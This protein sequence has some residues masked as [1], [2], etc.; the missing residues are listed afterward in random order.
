[1][2]LKSTQK[3][4]IHLARYLR[5]FFVGILAEPAF[6]ITRLPA[7]DGKRLR[8]TRGLKP[9]SKA[10]KIGGVGQIAPS[11]SACNNRPPSAPTSRRKAPHN[12]MDLPLVTLTTDFGTRDSYVA[13]MKGAML[14]RA[15]SLNIVDLSHD[16][17]PQDVALAARFISEACP[18]FP[19]GTI[20]VVVVDPGVGTDRSILLAELQ[21]QRFVCPDNGLLTYLCTSDASGT[22]RKLNAGKKYG[23][24]SQTFHGR[25]LMGPA[26]VDWALGAPIHECSVLIQDI[27]Q[28]PLSSPECGSHQCRGE[29]IGT[30]SFG[31]LITNVTVSCLPSPLPNKISVQLVGRSDQLTWVSTYGE[32]PQGCLVA[33]VGSSGRV[34]IAQVNGSAARQLG[35]QPNTEVHVAW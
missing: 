2:A 12:P 17:P 19:E 4:K 15:P 30:D 26:A 34:E 35:L 16:I 3:F 31:N 33:L 21:E 9:C 7:S 23:P 1:L 24:P 28:I 20:H 6:P 22:F 14:R 32:A 11:V 29:I 27:R 13:Q 25:D 8:S 18:R 5:A 10:A